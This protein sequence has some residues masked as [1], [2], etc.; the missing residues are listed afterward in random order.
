MSKYAGRGAL[1]FGGKAALGTAAIGIPAGILARFFAAHGR[2][3]KTGDWGLPKN[4]H[5]TW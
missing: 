2:E 1:D 4:N 5:V 3:E